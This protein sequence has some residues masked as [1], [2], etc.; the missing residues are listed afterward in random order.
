MNIASE[1]QSLIAA[2]YAVC[3]DC[4]HEF[5]PP[6]TRRHD[7]TASTAGLL[8]GHVTTTEYEVEDVR[9]S[10][11]H[12]RGAPED[13]PCTLRVE[14]RVGFRQRHSEWICFEHTGWARYRAESWWRS[15]SDAPVPE[16][17]AE[18]VD[19]AAAGALCETKSITV[20]SM[21]GEKYDRI[22]GHKLEA[23]PAWREP[24]WDEGEEEGDHTY[25]AVEGV[26]F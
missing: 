2:G 12:K 11:H 25:V 7:A 21:V 3:P 13:T 1:C 5:P 18:A 17:A 24:G 4:G 9:Y 14:Y 15:R 22:I 8:S 19:L 26:P 20:R 23:K 6:E 10:V 16:S